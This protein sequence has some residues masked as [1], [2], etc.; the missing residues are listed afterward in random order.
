MRPP[1]DR[2]GEWL[3]EVHCLYCWLC[4]GCLDEL[5]GVDWKPDN[6]RLAHKRVL[7]YLAARLQTYQLEQALQT[8]HSKRGEE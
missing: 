5:A 7:Q 1:C 2:C 4:L 6:P 3:G 8:S